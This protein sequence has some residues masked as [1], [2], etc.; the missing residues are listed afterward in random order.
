[1]V[2]RVCI[3]CFELN[4]THEVVSV[5]TLGHCA[6][7]LF[8]IEISVFGQALALKTQQGR[9]HALFQT[10]ALPHKEQET[11]PQQEPFLQCSVSYLHTPL[12]MF[13]V[14]SPSVLSIAPS[15]GFITIM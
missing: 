14:L 10:L 5:T 9:K 13:S 11:V 12:T 15:H 3:A 1:M 7:L 4:P 2:C 8:C 6:F